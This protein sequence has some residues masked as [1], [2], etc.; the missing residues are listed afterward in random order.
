MGKTFAAIGCEL[1]DWIARQTSLF[2][3][4]AGAVGFGG[5]RSSERATISS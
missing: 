2:V 1:E 4:S 5:Y 3:A